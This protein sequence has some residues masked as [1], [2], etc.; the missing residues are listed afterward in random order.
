MAITKKLGTKN[1]YLS[2]TQKG[3]TYMRVRRTHER[4]GVARQTRLTIDQKYVRSE[5]KNDEN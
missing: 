5:S 1:G 4:P 3:G 2:G